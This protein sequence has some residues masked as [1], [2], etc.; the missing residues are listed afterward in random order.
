MQAASPRLILASASPRRADL[1]RQ[2][3]FSFQVRAADVDEAVLPGEDAVR[4]AL[5][6][7]AIKAGAVAS[8]ARDEVVLGADT[9]VEAPDGELLGKPITGVG[10]DADAARMLRLLSGRTHRVI[11]GVCCCLAERME[12]AAAITYVTFQTLSDAEIESYVA[13][14]EPIGKAGAY[15]I[16]GRA[17]R[18]TSRIVGEYSNV[19]GLPLSTA[20]AMLAA[21]GIHPG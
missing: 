15:A 14:G 13:S 5:R 12:I 3:G 21:C 1:L 7:A 18:W 19:V 2:A 9:V 8:S 10:A 11:T 17:A 16:Q 6:L 4:L 20:A